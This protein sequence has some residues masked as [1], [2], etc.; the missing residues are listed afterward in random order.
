MTAR[1]W[2]ELAFGAVIV[3]RLWELDR[4]VQNLAAVIV[5]QANRFKS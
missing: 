1:D 2:I 5:R 3:W 4:S